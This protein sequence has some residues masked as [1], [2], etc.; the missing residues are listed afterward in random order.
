MDGCKIKISEK[1]IWNFQL[2]GSAR[3]EV[4]LFVSVASIVMSGFSFAFIQN[5]NR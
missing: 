4:I 3:Y 2:S 5:T 1:V